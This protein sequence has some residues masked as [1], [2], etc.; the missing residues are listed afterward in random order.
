MGRAHRLWVRPSSRRKGFANEVLR[1]SLIRAR[2]LGLRKVRLTCDKD[3]V[4]PMKTIL[5]NGGQFDG[6]EFVPEEKKVVS[7]FWISLK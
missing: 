1:Q 5:R 2:D 3:N 7:R 6:E 4:A